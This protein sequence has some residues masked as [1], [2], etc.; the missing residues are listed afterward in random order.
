MVSTSENESRGECAELE[1]NSPVESG[2]PLQGEDYRKKPVQ[3]LQAASSPRL[4]SVLI[5]TS[6]KKRHEELIGVL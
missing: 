4:I 1:E 2:D 3:V 5:D 6:A